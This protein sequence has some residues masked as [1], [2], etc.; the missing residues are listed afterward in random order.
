MYMGAIEKLNGSTEKSTVH[1]TQPRN[2][3]EKIFWRFRYRL[4]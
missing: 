3:S 2:G 1:M 4:R